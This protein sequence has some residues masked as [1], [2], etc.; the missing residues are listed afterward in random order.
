MRG[1]RVAGRA[2]KGE[3]DR[4]LE[5]RGEEEG[6]DGL[7][8]RLPTALLL[9]S[10]QVCGAEQKCLLELHKRKIEKCLEQAKGLRCLHPFF[11][12]PGRGGCPCRLSPG[13]HTGVWPRPVLGWRWIKLGQQGPGTETDDPFSAPASL[14]GAGMSL[15]KLR[16]TEL[17]LPT[18]THPLPWQ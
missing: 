5:G 7:Q 18:A 14:M 4:D 16:T 8:S 2:G 6:W 1:T 3:R 9:G 11:V 13:K 12:A 15:G 17:D 10:T